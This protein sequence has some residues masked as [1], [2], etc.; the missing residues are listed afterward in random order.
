VEYTKLIKDLKSELDLV[1]LIRRSF[2]SQP[3]SSFSNKQPITSLSAPFS[4][5]TT[6]NGGYL[7]GSPSSVKLFK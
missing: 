6:S 2:E 5:A 7:F 4:A 1:Q 3:D